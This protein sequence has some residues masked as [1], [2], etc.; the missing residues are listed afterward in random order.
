MMYGLVAARSESTQVLVSLKSKLTVTYREALADAGWNR[1]ARENREERTGVSGA[2]L[3]I[4]IGAE[5]EGECKLRY[6]S[7]ECWDGNGGP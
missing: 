5:K 1:E 3:E 6:F 4:G 7:G 2:Y